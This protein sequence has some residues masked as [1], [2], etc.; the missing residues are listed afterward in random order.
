MKTI[1]ITVINVF[2]LLSC[3][4]E[5]KDKTEYIVS[6]SHQLIQT[7]DSIGFKLNDETT[8]LIKALFYYEDISGEEY[9]AFQNG[10]NSEIQFYNLKSREL[11]H[12]LRFDEG[13]ENFAGIFLGFHI[14]NK[15]EIYLT[16]IDKN[17]VCIS[18][19]YGHIYKRI[20]YPETNKREFIFPSM[21]VSFNYTPLVIKDHTIYLPQRYIADL[22]DG[23]SPLAIA[24]DTC[25][26]YVSKLPFNFPLLLSSKDFL[27]KSLNIEYGYSR[28]FDNNN[29]VYSFFFDEDI[30]IVNMNHSKIRKLKVKSK[31]LPKIKFERNNSLDLNV[32]LKKMNEVA[33]YGNLLYDKYR[34]VYYR[35]VYPETEVTT[36][37]NLSDLWQFGRKKFSV[38]V[39]DRNFNILGETLFPEGLYNSTLT[40]INKEGIYISTSHILNPNYNDGILSFKCFKIKEI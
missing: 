18:N 25:R 3:N 28:C 23:E 30:Y 32:A 14:Q 33:M 20:P 29:F 27:T 1:I 35:F 22:P 40:F 21:S 12:V 13:G 6:G 7:A 2:I 5:S 38:I 8:L 24:I 36:K 37:T 15:D 10:H 11:D 34:Q 17:E 9:V 39:L 31:Y 16:R 4:Y 19:Y 26:Q